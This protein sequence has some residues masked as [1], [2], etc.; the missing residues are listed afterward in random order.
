MV[1]AV[2]AHAR[3]NHC[4]QRAVAR[5]ET[6]GPYTRLTS[7]PAWEPF[8][9]ASS[10]ATAALAGLIFVAISI[11]LDDILETPGLDRRALEALALLVGALILSLLVLIPSQPSAAFGIEA[12]ITGLTLAFLTT[13]T[14][15]IVR[16]W[17]RRPLI[18]ALKVILALASVPPYF[19]VAAT[20]LTSAPSL[21]WLAAAVLL[22]IVSATA[23][24][25]VLLVEIKR[26]LPRH[27]A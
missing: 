25:W 18:V 8:F 9:I 20:A 26:N 24:G 16:I 10:G 5:T 27:A 22:S 1:S 21:G 15:A 4:S 19:V 2:H 6:I 11:N 7:T 17:H 23:S 13:R 12:G 14:M 3:R